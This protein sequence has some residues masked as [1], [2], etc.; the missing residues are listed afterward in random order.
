[1]DWTTE[2]PTKPGWYWAEE[3]CEL[4]DDPMHGEVEAVRVYDDQ[5]GDGVLTARWRDVDVP[6]EQITERYWWYG[7]VPPPPRL[8]RNP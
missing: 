1:M 6:F 2:T 4:P 5:W 7:P 3:I 8:E